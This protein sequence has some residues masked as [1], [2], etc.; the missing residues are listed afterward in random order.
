MEASPDDDVTSVVT[1]MH[2]TGVASV[3]LTATGNAYGYVS[4]ADITAALSRN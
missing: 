2:A 4:G 3:V 1:A